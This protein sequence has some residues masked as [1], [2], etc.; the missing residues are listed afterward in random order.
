M[1]T[2]MMMLIF[3][4]SGRS[5]VEVVV[6]VAEII[7]MTTEKSQHWWGF[8]EFSGRSGRILNF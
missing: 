5:V 8:R 7:T 4:P 1:L 2:G 6:E 3:F